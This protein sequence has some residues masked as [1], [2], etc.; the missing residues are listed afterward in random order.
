MPVGTKV[1]VLCLHEM[2][3]IPQCEL[4]RVHDN[5]DQQQTEYYK[6][7]ICTWLSVDS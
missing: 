5:A 7:R 2:H 4:R 1:G 6:A 3:I